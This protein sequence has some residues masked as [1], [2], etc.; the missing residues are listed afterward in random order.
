MSKR[1]VFWFVV[2]VLILSLLGVLS[3]GCVS[4]TY[5]RHNDKG[6]EV[7]RTKQTHFAPVYAPSFVHD[8]P[9]VY[10]RG[11]FRYRSPV[12]RTYGGYCEPP[13]RVRRVG[14][15]VVIYDSHHRHHH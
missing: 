12:V 3:A 7:E 6:E 11:G 1:Q 9:Y 13:V 2:V 4:T 8:G 5:V 10:T 14:R 15:P